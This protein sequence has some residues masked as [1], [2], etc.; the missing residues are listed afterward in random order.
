MIIGVDREWRK[1]VCLLLRHWRTIKMGKLVFIRKCMG[2]SYWVLQVPG[3]SGVDCHSKRYLLWLLIIF[4]LS[5]SIICTAW[6]GG[7][8]KKEENNNN[9]KEVMKQDFHWHRSPSKHTGIYF[10]EHQVTRTRSLMV[11]LNKEIMS[12]VKI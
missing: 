4:N 1:W 2:Q 3:R 9:K 6:M 11:S 8:N 10:K 7:K 12:S 5:M